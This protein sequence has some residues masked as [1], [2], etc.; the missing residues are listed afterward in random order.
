MEETV[1]I[2]TPISIAS[3]K[4]CSIAPPKMYSISTT[5]R[6]VPEVISVRLSVWVNDTFMIS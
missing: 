1:P 4:P 6:V 2:D 5:I 3:E